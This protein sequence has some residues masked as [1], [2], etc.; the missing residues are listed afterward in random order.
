MG[1]VPQIDNERSF[2]NTGYVDG[3]WKRGET[4]GGCRNYLETFAMNPQYLTIVEDTDEDDDELCTMIIGI[5][6]KGSRRRKAENDED[7]ALT[8]GFSIYHIKD[9]E[10]TVLP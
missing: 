4:A 8:I 7:G 3:S 2:W 9:P 5:M 10:N 6:Q 1:D